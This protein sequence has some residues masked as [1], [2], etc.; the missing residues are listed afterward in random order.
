MWSIYVLIGLPQLV[1]A[2]LRRGHMYGDSGMENYAL[3]SQAIS[4]G[5]EIIVVVFL[6][7]KA[8]WLASLVFPV[9][10]EFGVAFSAADFRTVLFATVGLYF[11]LDGFRHAV[12]IAYLL[13]TR[14]RGDSPNAASYLWE[15]NPETLARSLGGIVAGGLLLIGRQRLV[16]FWNHYFGRAP[17]T[18]EPELVDE[19]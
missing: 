6:L 16:D 1:N 8:A 4:L 9:E 2:L 15:R 14:P 7:R 10:R 18:D 17:E 12:G 3:S 11:L 13:A 19:E 5:C